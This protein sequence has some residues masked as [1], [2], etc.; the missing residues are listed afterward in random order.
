M[1]ND[2]DLAVYAARLYA[3]RAE[4]IIVRPAT[5]QIG[6]WTPD[7]HECHGNVTPFCEVSFNHSP[8][9]GWLYFD[10]GGLL[11]FVR[12]N[13]N[14]VVMDEHSMLLDITPTRA[15]ERYP[16]IRAEESEREYAELFEALKRRGLRHVDHFLN[17]LDL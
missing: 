3:R 12:F 9:R 11:P 15:S 8:V 14:S 6:D 1:L 7:E 5:V 4:G 16:F 2:E 13:T 10:F 17:A